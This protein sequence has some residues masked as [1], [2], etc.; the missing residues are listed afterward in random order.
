M[1][2]DVLYYLID[3][4]ETHSINA[5]AQRFF[6]TQPAI[7]KAIVNLE[8]SMGVKLLERSAHGVVPTAEGRKVI[9]A[10][11]KI[12]HEWDLLEQ[13]LHQTAADAVQSSFV[14]INILCASGLTN[15][16]I[17]PMLEAVDKKFP[18]VD[19]AL[20]HT[21]SIEVFLR[22]F[23][24]YNGTT[25]IFLVTSSKILYNSLLEQLSETNLELIKLSDDHLVACVS[26]KFVNIENTE[27]NTLQSNQHHIK[28]CAFG[29][30][31]ATRSGS[32][33]EY[34]DR[35]RNNGDYA[36]KN[37]SRLL[38]NCYDTEFYK[39]ILSKKIIVTMPYMVYEAYFKSKRFQYKEMSP[40]DA[41]I[42]DVVH[43]IIYRKNA[44]KEAAELV[45]I[46][47]DSFFSKK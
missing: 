35:Y 24:D 39:Y 37:Y 10:A 42:Y 2:F 45:K 14:P 11:K 25:D 26:N 20:K 19:V 21:S 22:Q 34:L 33:I 3:I 30:L 41:S 32:Y 31:A 1:R 15:L 6:I 12:L 43:M 13:N 40:Y 27:L 23:Y 5:T 8:K 47:R 44:P 29:S 17:P 16:L 4:D 36:Q 28:G 18:H 9:E 38:S 7:S 46:M